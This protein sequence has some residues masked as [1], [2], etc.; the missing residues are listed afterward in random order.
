MLVV[1]PIK[2]E[3]DAARGLLSTMHHLTMGDTINCCLV[4]IGNGEIRLGLASANHH[5]EEILYPVLKEHL[6]VE[7]EDGR[8]WQEMFILQRHSSTYVLNLR[9]PRPGQLPNLV[10]PRFD[11]LAALFAALENVPAQEA[12]GVSWVLRAA[13][14]DCWRAHG[15]AFATGTEQLQIYDRASHLAAAYASLQFKHARSPLF[16]KWA[17]SSVL[18]L[19]MRMP[20]TVIDMN[21]AAIVWHPPLEI[22]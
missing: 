16:Q 5:T 10:A 15:V 13:E 18:A 12:A 3:W 9:P 22:G 4:G 7:P 11:P 19:K 14:N 21:S 8:H 1:K 17:W 2:I 6:G 20:Q